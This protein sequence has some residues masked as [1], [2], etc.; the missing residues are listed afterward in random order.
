[1]KSAL[2]L[3]FVLFALV[4]PALSEESLFLMPRDADR[5]L[6]A[7]S[8]DLKNAQKSIQVAIYSFTHKKVADSIKSAAR[9][10]VRVTLLFDEESNV[11][12]PYSRLGDLAKL[13]NITAYTLK[14]LPNKKKGYAGKMHMKMA[15]IDGKKIYFGSANWSNSAFSLSY[16]LLYR[17]DSPEIIKQ[18]QAYFSQMTRQA[19][20]Y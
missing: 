3:L 1:M 11:K 13:K 4:L 15:I 2:L 19:K 20:P 7:L 5:A 12:K 18:S 9:R 6:E 16:E 8:K 14:G 17:S 10:G